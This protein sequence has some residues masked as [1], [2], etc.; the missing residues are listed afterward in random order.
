[1]EILIVTVFLSLVLAGSAVA[2]FAWSVKEGTYEHADRLALLP[3]EDEVFDN[4]VVDP[5]LHGRSDE[6]SSASEGE[7]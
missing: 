3:L 4:R 2:F 5:I 6:S 1:M 7:S